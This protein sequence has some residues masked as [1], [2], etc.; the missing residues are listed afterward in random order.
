MQNKTFL[1]VIALGIF[2]G[3]LLVSTPYSD[4]LGKTIV[5]ERPKGGDFTMQ[6]ADG[7]LSLSD[8]KGKLVLLYFGYTYCP[9]IC[10]TDLGKLAAAYKKLTPSE[11]QKVQILFVSVDPERDNVQR[12]KTYMDY[13]EADIIGMTAS[14]NYLS[15]ISKN[16]GV[17]Y[18]KVG[19]ENDHKFYT[20]DHSAFTY[21]I[22]Q[23]G[24]LIEQLPHGS[25]S[26]LIAEKIKH[27]LK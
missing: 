5:S 6:T 18:S 10:P 11:Q 12:L 3:I 23:Q 17:I 19:N 22:N 8:F 21:I 9:D 4:N 16:Y 26:T 1:A 20:V 24:H 14:P 25:A 7:S 15:I 13:F 27:N 2:F